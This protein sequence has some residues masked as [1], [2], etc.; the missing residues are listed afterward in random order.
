MNLYPAIERAVNSAHHNLDRSMEEIEFD[1]ADLQAVMSLLT[2]SDR[3]EQAIETC[4]TLIMDIVCR[5]D[6]SKPNE[7]PVNQEVLRLGQIAIRLQD[8]IKN[9][10]RRREIPVDHDGGLLL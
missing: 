3:T 6:R 10:P 4:T 5:G 1:P 2:S 7:D 8:I 9:R